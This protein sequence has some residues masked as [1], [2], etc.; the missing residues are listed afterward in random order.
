MYATEYQSN[1]F[2]EEDMNSDENDNIVPKADYADGNNS[3]E[4]DDSSCR[5]ETEQAGR[6]F[7]KKD[8]LIPQPMVQMKSRCGQSVYISGHDRMLSIFRTVAVQ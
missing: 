1:V 7:R 6:M 5:M 3:P 2:D 8:R 4:N